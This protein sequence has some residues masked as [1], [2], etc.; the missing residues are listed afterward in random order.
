MSDMQLIVGVL[1]FVAV[2]LAGVVA[3][4]QRT[5]QSE[6]AQLAALFGPV[7]DALVRQA[8]TILA[9]YGA[10]LRPLH[11]AAQLAE[12]LV[13]EPGDA[14]IQALERWLHADPDAAVAALKPF[15]A[16]IRALTDGEAAPLAEREDAGR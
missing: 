4:A 6:I 7:L 3:Y 2:A 11:E 15:F 12:S 16:S 13:D 9:P 10:Q 8:D 5:R 1:G 14:I